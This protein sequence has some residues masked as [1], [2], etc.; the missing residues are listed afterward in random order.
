MISRAT[1]HVLNLSNPVVTEININAV[2]V[3]SSMDNV[4]IGVTVP[5]V[6]HFT[7][8]TAN[9]L[10]VNGGSVLSDAPNNANTYGRKGGAW[11][12][13]ATPDTS[14]FITDAPIDAS[15]YV[16][17]G[18]SWYNITGLGY[19]TDASG[20]INND[21][22]YYA[23][24]NGVWAVVSSG[25]SGVGGITDAPNSSNYLRTNGA[26]VNITT[27]GF[28]TDAPNNTNT[29][30]R[31]GA[32]WV[33]LSTE[34]FISDAPSNG[35]TYG[36][37]DGAW[38]SMASSDIATGILA[39]TVTFG[40]VTGSDTVGGTGNPRSNT[41]PAFTGGSALSGTVSNAS[42][43]GYLAA[44]VN[45]VTIANGQ[46]FTIPANTWYMRTVVTREYGPDEGD[47]GPA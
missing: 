45:N 33:N 42:F 30:G 1:K 7:N 12:T 14:A 6:G 46:S 10:T 35:S 20:S 39:N 13:I 37:K 44:M 34:G 4:P 41:Y 9:S 28:L 21:G 24:R 5:N 36:R 23:R 31:K 8:L 47:G 15:R 27:L 2:G 3:T 38:V 16:R 11:V 25:S 19:I 40:V 18:G 29:Y 22:N 17:S 26:W 32:A 43:Q